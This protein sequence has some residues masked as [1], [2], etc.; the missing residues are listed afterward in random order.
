LYGFGGAAGG[1]TY[2]SWRRKDSEM[3]IGKGDR[4]YRGL[5]RL[6]LLP[7][8]SSGLTDYNR[9]GRNNRRTNTRARWR[10]G[11]KAHAGPDVSQPHSIGCAVRRDRSNRSRSEWC[12]GLVWTP[13]KRRARC[14]R[15]TERRLQLLFRWAGLQYRRRTIAMNG[16][17]ESACGK[18]GAQPHS[19]ECPVFR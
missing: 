17:H 4:D 10:V 15:R 11:Q 1:G 8:T 9:A 19:I 5:S 16:K 6:S 12:R 18:Y 7:T 14:R 3:T 13:Y 2:R